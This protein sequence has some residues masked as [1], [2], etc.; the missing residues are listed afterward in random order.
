[1]SLNGIV[2]GGGGMVV[3]SYKENN[4][5][6]K[7]KERYVQL[8]NGHTLKLSDSDHLPNTFLSGRG[9]STLS[10][11]TRIER[12][13]TAFVK[14]DTFSVVEQYACKQHIIIT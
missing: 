2:N 4:I 8:C 11:S 9:Q 3:N 5:N 14:R 12:S 1:M 13:T 6:G 7:G 10:Y